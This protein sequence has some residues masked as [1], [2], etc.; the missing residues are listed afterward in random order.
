MLR[1]LSRLLVKVAGLVIVIHSM[2]T[3]PRDAVSALAMMRRDTPGS[4]LDHIEMPLFWGMTVFPTLIS[5]ALG[6]CLFWGAGYITNR[7]IVHHADGGGAMADSRAIEEV[8]VAVLGYYLIAVGLSDAVYDGVSLYGFLALSKT[9][10]FMPPEK[11]LNL[12]VDGVRTAIGIGLV[13]WA[14]GLVALRRGVIAL[15]AMG[16]RP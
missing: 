7:H 3:L 9:W 15:R 8:A 2:A 12:V 13:L 11:I 10:E 5:I 16:N 1:S 14:G 6:L 4:L